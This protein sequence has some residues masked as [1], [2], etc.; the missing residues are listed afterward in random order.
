[1]RRFAR[2]KFGVRADAAGI[3]AR[4]VDNVRF[5]SKREADRYRQLKELLNIGYI[6]GL[7]LQPRYPLIVN[8]VKICDYVADFAYRDREGRPV[9]EDSKGMRT[10]VFILKSKLFAVCYPDLRIIEV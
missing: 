7:R 5:H 8:G 2:T 9:I 10:A 4:T 1:M 6:S 3:A